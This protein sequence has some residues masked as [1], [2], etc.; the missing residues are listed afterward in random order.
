MKM[1]ANLNYILKVAQGLSRLEKIT[2]MEKLVHQLKIENE[3]QE[4]SINWEKMY[5]IGKGIWKA[6]A[7]DYVNQLREDR[8]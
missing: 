1:Q 5:G 2:L 7:Q 3:E 6:D 4:E 8:I